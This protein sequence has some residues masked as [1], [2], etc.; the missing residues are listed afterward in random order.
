[1]KKSD[2]RICSWIDEIKNGSFYLIKEFSTGYAVLSKYQYNYYKG[3]AVF[4]CKK[5]IK[6][7]HYLEDNFRLRFLDEM[8]Q[9]GKAVY[10]A[11]GPD[12]LNYE[13]LG[14]TEP[15]LHW[16]IFPRYKIDPNFTKPI[17]IVDK[18]IRQSDSTIV[19]EK[20]IQTLKNKMLN[21]I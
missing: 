1:M 11:F 21:Y 4:I 15:H 16:H 19:A 2:C 9:I 3:Y 8:S 14:N 10:K 18:K 5:H 17:W 20:E 13:L 6:E 7:L 12:K